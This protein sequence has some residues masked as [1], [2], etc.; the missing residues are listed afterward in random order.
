MKSNW[1]KNI[2]YLVIS[3]ICISLSVFN[4][5]T[6]V[7]IAAWIGP[8]LL[9]RFIRN[10]KWLISVLFSFI[11][12]QVSFMIGMIPFGNDVGPAFQLTFTELIVMQ[13]ESGLLFLVPVILVPFLLDKALYKR[14]PKG[15]A[16]LIYPL[17]V[18]VLEY[19]TAL[20]TGTFNTF[21]ETQHTSQHIS[22]W[23]SI[24]GI[25]G[26]SFVI[27]WAASIFNM[28]W[29]NKWNIKSMGKTGLVFSITLSVLLLFS[30]FQLAYPME[31]KEEVVVAGVIPESELIET[32]IET[33]LPIRELIALS[34][35]EYANYLNSSDK[36][37]NELKIRIVESIDKGAKII[38]LPEFSFRLI[39]NKA[40]AYIE[41]LREIAMEYQVYLVISY[42]RILDKKERKE[43]PESNMSICITPKGETA[44]EY[45]KA[46]P[47]PGLETHI[48]QAGSRDIPFV[49]TPYGR[50]G[51][52]ICADTVFPH[53]IKQ[54]ADKDIDILLNPSW[55]G[56]AFGLKIGYISALRAVEN[57]FTM[58]RISS[59]GLTAVID[60]QFTQWAKYDGMIE[61]N[62]DFYAKIPVISGNTIYGKIGYLFPILCIFGLTLIPLFY[63][64]SRGKK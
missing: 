19:L 40:D 64:V 3:T 49:D 16:T 34:P 47:N 56:K 46:Y 48:V 20:R 30:G 14:L 27:C 37:L 21:G 41:T 44:W 52:V 28:L 17:T 22:L 32:I 39:S 15:L 2:I 62:T 24:A 33:G 55:D 53:F 11:I 9:M 63:I 51:E 26:I 8:I 61:E 45:A 12:L 59:G 60:P 57:G 50:I 25:Y 4:F 58:V 6:S 18:V 29:E 42:A 1:L 5:G 36:R 31:S 10:N 54:A 35:E 13:A 7:W 43:K 23:A 38:V